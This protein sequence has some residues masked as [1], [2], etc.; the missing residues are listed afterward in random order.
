MVSLSGMMLLPVFQSNIALEGS[1]DAHRENVVD[2][3]L[4]TFLVTRPDIFSYRFCGSLIDDVAGNLDIDNSSH[5][6]YGCLTAW[7]LAHEQRHKTYATLLAEKLGCEFR[8]PFSVFGT[9]RLNIFTDDYDRQLKNETN[10]F[11]S[12]LFGDKY[13]YNLSAWWHPI[14]GI[15]FGGEF[16]IGE[17]PPTKDCYVAR[18][19]IMMPY[20]PVLSFGNHTVVFTKQ[21]LKHQLFHNDVGFGRS[22]IPAIDNL[23][24]IFENYTNRNPPFDV[25]E[26]AQRATK[27]NLSTLVYGF[28]IYGIINESNVTVFPGIVNMTLTRGFETIRRIAQKGLAEAFNESF[29]EA[30]RVIDRLFGSLN[31]SIQD[32]LSQSILGQ[33]NVTLQGLLNQSFASLDEAFTACESMIEEYITTLV[34]EFIEPLIETFVDSVFDVLDTIIDFTEMLI[35][36]L[37]SH[38]CL[39]NAE[40]MLTIWVVRE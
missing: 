17:Q 20:L 10:S 7:L 38:I 2:D 9:N 24:I 29:G 4:R 16:S 31:T 13:H 26:N 11:F 35:D 22:S 32:P 23:S 19:L 27:E 5:G 1:L 18:S 28:L 3:A 21:W 6:L 8:L 12:S 34:R 14:K 15:S 25:K 37:C 39:D 30:I 33:F 36:W 40:V